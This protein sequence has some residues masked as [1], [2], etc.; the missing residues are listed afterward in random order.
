MG[1]CSQKTTVVWDYSNTM[2]TIPIPVVIHS[3]LGVWNMTFMTFNISG[4]V[5]P[6]DFHIFQRG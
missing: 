5:T 3:Y 2:V 4:I 1:S 6:T